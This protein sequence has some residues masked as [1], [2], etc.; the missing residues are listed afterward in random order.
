MKRIGKLML[1]GQEW[2]IIVDKDLPETLDGLALLEEK[3]I[4]IS[5]SLDKKGFNHCILHEFFHAAL[6]EASF[7]AIGLPV[8]AE[9]LL[10][11]LLAKQM[12][13]NFATLK[14]LLA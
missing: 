11:D 4:L 1:L 13:A 7:G 3:K 14:R 9:E 6:C 5:A 2:E 12:M 8:E 10:V